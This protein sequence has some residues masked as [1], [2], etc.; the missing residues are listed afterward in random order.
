M[1]IDT[2]YNIVHQLNHW[3][4]WLKGTTSISWRQ[5][6]T[7]KPH[8][9]SMNYILGY[10]RTE[11]DSFPPWPGIFFKLA[12]CGY[13][14]RVTPQTSY[15]PEYTTPTQKKKASHIIYIS[16]ICLQSANIHVFLVHNKLI[17]STKWQL[18]IYILYFNLQPWMLVNI[19]S[20]TIL[21]PIHHSRDLQ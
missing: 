5:C 18:H 7:N 6:A 1:I 9:Y 16:T 14:L 4:N 21:Y 13:T 12:R 20:T 8:P 17:C 15:S 11:T 3:L 2:P 10:I 19:I